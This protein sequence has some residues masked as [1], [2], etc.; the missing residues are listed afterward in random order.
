MTAKSKMSL[1]QM[2]LDTATIEALELLPNFLNG[3]Q[4]LLE[5]EEN[6]C[7]VN[8]K[9]RESMSTSQEFEILHKLIIKICEK[10]DLQCEELDEYNRIVEEAKKGS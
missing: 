4:Y 2:G 8:K 5:N 1:S 6:S 9:I 10:I 7:R 3:N